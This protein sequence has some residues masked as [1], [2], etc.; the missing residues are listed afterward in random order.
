LILSLFAGVQV[1]VDLLSRMS[2]PLIK[3][4]LG[5][6][7]NLA[8]GAVSSQSPTDIIQQLRSV[9]A[10]EPT[11]HQGRSTSE[12]CRLVVEYAQKEID[13]A[14]MVRENAKYLPKMALSK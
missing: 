2:P 11:G 3:A 9:R 14:L 5:L 8:T 1:L 13:E 4:T 12:L 10:I 6:L 7:R